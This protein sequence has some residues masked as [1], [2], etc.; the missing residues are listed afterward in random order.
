LLMIILHA[1]VALRGLPNKLIGRSFLT[2]SLVY[3]NLT[4]NR[5]FAL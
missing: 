1:I 5:C 3:D 4:Y 2:K